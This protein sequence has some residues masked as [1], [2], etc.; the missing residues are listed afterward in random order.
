M[1]GYDWTPEFYSLWRKVAAY[2]HA[3]GKPEAARE[4][5]SAVYHMRNI[6]DLREL[7]VLYGYGRLARLR[8]W[9][10]SLRPLKWID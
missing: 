5:C 3:S 2:L 1:K 10:R 9:L 6:E 7:S 8:T 4:F